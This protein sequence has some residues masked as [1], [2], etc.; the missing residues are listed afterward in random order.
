MTKFKLK[1]KRTKGNTKGTKLEFTTHT[2]NQTPE[3][4]SLLYTVIKMGE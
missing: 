3:A 1:F 2:I 4:F